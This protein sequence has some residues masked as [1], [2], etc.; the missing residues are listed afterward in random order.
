[1]PASANKSRLPLEPGVNGLALDSTGNKHTTD[2]AYQVELGAVSELLY[3][4]GEVLYKL[5]LSA[6]SAAGAATLTFKAGAVTLKTIALDL[7]T[8]TVFTGREVVSLA[9]LEGT[10]GIAVTLSVD[11]AADAGI[12]AALY[13]AVDIEIP[14]VSGC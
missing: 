8:A 10:Q 12:T 11:T 2:T 14:L 5:A 4:R 9:G 1:M 13:T 3:K 7:T 6:A